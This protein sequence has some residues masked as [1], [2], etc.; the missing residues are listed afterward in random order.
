MT[1]SQPSNLPCPKEGFDLNPK[2]LCPLQGRGLTQKIAET[3]DF[4]PFWYRGTR[5]IFFIGWRV[6]IA[7]SYFFQ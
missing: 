4:L 3:D 2:P 6:E 7:A 1:F 5:D